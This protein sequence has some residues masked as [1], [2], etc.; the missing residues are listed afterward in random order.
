MDKLGSIGFSQKN[1]FALND[2]RLGTT[3]LPDVIDWDP[4]I[5]LR[6]RRTLAAHPYDLTCHGGKPLKPLD[7]PYDNRQGGNTTN[8]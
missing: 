7:R 8:L 4:M 1:K 2:H 3:S 5:H 6:S